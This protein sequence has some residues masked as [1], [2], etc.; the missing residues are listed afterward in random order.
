MDDGKS[1]RVNKSSFEVKTTSKLVHVEEITPNVIEP[2]FGIGR[3]LYIVLEHNFRKRDGDSNSYFAL[4]ALIA[5][6][7]CSILP[8]SNKPEF[9]PFIKRIC[10]LSFSIYLNEKHIESCIEN[11]IYIFAASLLLDE[12]V[13]HKID[14][15]SGSIGRRYVR[16][17]E[18]GIP[19]NVT[20][21]FDSPKMPN[22]VTIR[23]RDT[24]EQLRIP[25]RDVGIV[26]RDLSTNKLTWQQLSQ[27]YP[28]FEKQESDS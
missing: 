27:K 1:V 25:L 5:A 11:E 13:S 22:T 3:I 21:D 28:K 20:I 12:D 24:K 18:I 19:F 16:S 17:D 8:L 6:H 23:E 7:K 10:E 14:D 15:M 9:Q 4:P 26:I 2:S